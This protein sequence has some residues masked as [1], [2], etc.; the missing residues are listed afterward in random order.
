MASLTRIQM[1]PRSPNI[2]SRPRAPA[3]KKPP[4]NGVFLLAGLPGL[5]PRLTESES[6]VLPLDDSPI[7]NFPYYA[8]FN[9]KIN[10]NFKNLINKFLKPFSPDK[11]CR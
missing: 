8:Y 10:K 9:L 11:L 3:I 7:T 1:H 2:G 4:M 6:A 5:E